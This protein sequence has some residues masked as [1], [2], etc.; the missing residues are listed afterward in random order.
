MHHFHTYLRTGLIVLLFVAGYQTAT[1]SQDKKQ[2]IEQ[3][4]TEAHGLG[5]FN[6]NVLVMQSGKPVYQASFGN[7]DPLGKEKLTPEY[8]FNIGSIAKEFNAV[9]IMM[10]K[11]Q[12]KL[13]LDDSISKYLPELPA[14]AGKI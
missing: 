8:R 11:E 2:K 1:F 7:A 5:L 9:A 6:G 13:N 3:L 14:W 12:H 4:M 10:L